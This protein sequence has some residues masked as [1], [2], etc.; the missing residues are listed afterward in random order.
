MVD[1]LL[2]RLLDSWIVQ[3]K[4]PDEL[5]VEF[6]EDS[7]GYENPIIYFRWLNTNKEKIYG[8]TKKRFDIVFDKFNAY[9]NSQN[10]MRA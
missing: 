1:D 5:S 6:D 2:V 3:N 7:K 4:V 8:Y 9:W 10:S